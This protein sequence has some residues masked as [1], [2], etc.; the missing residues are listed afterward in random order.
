[1]AVTF[2]IIIFVLIFVLALP[3]G[4]IVLQIYLSRRESHW[5]GLVLPL[6]TFLYAFLIVYQ[7]CRFFP[8]DWNL[9]A[10]FTAWLAGNI[11]TVILLAIYWTIRKKRRVEEQ[12]DRMKIDDL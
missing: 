4:A 8:D 11:P 1:M 6:L 12:L 9:I 7:K 5:P 10:V 3:I 2:N